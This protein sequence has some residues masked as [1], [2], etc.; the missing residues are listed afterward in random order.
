MGFGAVAGGADVAVGAVA[1]AV[2]GGVAG[3]L[4]GGV[5]GGA[6][7]EVGGVAGGATG[8]AGVDSVSAAAESGGLHIMRADFFRSSDVSVVPIIKDILEKLRSTVARPNLP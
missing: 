3:G 1:G 5:A 8:G 4:A 6:D 7:V 2:A